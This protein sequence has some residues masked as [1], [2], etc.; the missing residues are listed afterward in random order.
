MACS[1]NHQLSAIEGVWIGK[2]A[3]EV[4]QV[5]YPVLLDIRPGGKMIRT[6]LRDLQ[7]DST[8][9]WSL[10]DSLLT[11]D[12]I[13][14]QVRSISDEELVLF[15]NYEIRFQRPMEDQ[16]AMPFKDVEKRMRSN[17]WEENQNDHSALSR[18][19]LRYTPVNDTVILT[20]EFRADDAV[21]YT[22]FEVSAY[23]LFE[24]GSHIF[25]CLRSGPNSGG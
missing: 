1:Q 17:A 18:Q 7:P 13:R 20:R 5:H 22:E 3:H 10:K 15:K 23:Q 11:I 21:V 6:D 8:L 9:S 12:T 2:Y 14:Y 24:V 19:Y 16:V 25:L 4:Y